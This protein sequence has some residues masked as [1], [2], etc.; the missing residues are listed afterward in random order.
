LKSSKSWNP[1]KI[2]DGGYDAMLRAIRTDRAPNLFV[3]Q[4][5]SSWLVQN[6]MLIPRF[7][8]TE[9]I[10]EKRRPL[11]LGARRAGWIGCNILLGKIPADG[12]IAVVSDGF[13][14]SARSVRQQFSRMRGLSEMPP[15]LRG[16]T[17]DVLNVI[18]RLDKAQFSLR[19]LY[20]FESE[21]RAAHPHNQNVRPKMRQQLQV[22][23]DLGLL[24][25]SHPG[26]YALRK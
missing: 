23:R 3:L 10:I 26:H 19:E 13:P 20:A 1:K 21:L 17:I 5:S 4:Y 12:K 22:L 16:W 2:V 14:V 11:S 9:S 6:L 25:F 18:R 8:F 7:F 24:E 15:S